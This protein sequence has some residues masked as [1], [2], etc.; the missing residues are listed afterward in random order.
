MLFGGQNGPSELLQAPYT[1]CSAQNGLSQ[2][3]Q[4]YYMLCGGQNGLSKL[5]HAPTSFAVV[6]TDFPIFYNPPTRFYMSPTH[7]VV[8]RTGFQALTSFLHALQW[9][10]WNPRSSTCLLHALPWSKW[11]IRTS[12][13]FQ[14][15]LCMVVKTHFPSFHKPSSY[16]LRGGENGLS[17]R[18]HAC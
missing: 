7:I 11:T 15:A 17:K 4:G 13:S 8:C 16:T 10:K 14:H 5:I 2:I 6:K 1:I 3:L 9:S 12:T 18:I